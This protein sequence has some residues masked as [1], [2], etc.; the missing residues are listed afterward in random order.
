MLEKA[1]IEERALIIEDK[2]FGELIYRL[3]KPAYAVV[4]LRF[5]VHE[6]HLKWA[7]LKQFI[8]EYGYRLEGLFVAVDTEKFRSRPLSWQ[9]KQ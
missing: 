8:N 6:R 1:F 4:L 5:D 9:A 2:D 7:R 3:K